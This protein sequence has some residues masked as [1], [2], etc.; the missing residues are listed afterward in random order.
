MSRIGRV[1]YVATAM[2]AACI[3]G[4]PAQAGTYTV[5]A[6]WEAT[7]DG[8]HPV[9]L[10]PSTEVRSDCAG[11]STG[12]PM[13]A[14]AWPIDAVWPSGA[15]TGWAFTAP[16]GTRI[17]KFTAV[18]WSSAGNSRVSIARPWFRGV[19]DPDSAAAA[20]IEGSEK[21]VTLGNLNAERVVFGLRCLDLYCWFPGW[22]GPYGPGIGRTDYIQ[23]VAA[24]S[25]TL[26][27]RD[28]ESPTVNLRQAPSHAWTS[29]NS[30]H[31]SVDATDNVGVARINALLNTTTKATS[32]GECSGG[33]NTLRM[34]C[35]RTAPTVETT[36]DLSS[37]DDG[38]HE[39]KI[40]AADASGNE[41]TRVIPVWLDRA[42]PRAPR[43]LTVVGGDG[44][45]AGDTMAVTWLN[46]PREN[47]GVVAAEYELCPNDN[48]VGDLD[49]C[50]RGER[51]GADIARIDDLAVPHSGAWR[52]RIAL[53]DEAGNIDWDQTADREGIEFDSDAPSASFL[54][55]DP[56]D[57]A[58]VWL[59]AADDMSGVAG[60]E[61]EARRQGATTWHSLPT[62][63]SNGRFTA[64]LNDAELPE[65]VYSLRALVRDR[66]GHE[67][68]AMTLG[69]G[70]SLEIRLPVRADSALA[71]GRP[72]RVR[73]KSAKGK[74]KR[75]RTVLVPKP[76]T[77]YGDPVE[78]EGT[79]SDRV[80]N[81]RAGTEVKVLERV[82]LPGRDWQEIASVRTGSG[83]A[84]K[85]RA[86]PGPARALRFQYVGTA[87]TRPH[88]QDVELRVRAGVTLIPSRRRVRNGAQITF[89]GRVL[90][91]P[92]PPA[93]KILALQAQTS[94]GWRTF[95]TPRARA[96][97]GRFSVP[98]RFL[99]TTVTSRYRFRVVVPEESSYPYASGS[100][101]I[102]SVLVRG[103][104]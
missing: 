6:C 66:A 33:M 81:P 32:T 8:W 68:T 91:G 29:S 57:P 96:T 94:R 64:L 60:V 102:T 53:R 13:R 48:D 80:G 59:T 88:S 99:S 92:I 39:V 18:G 38:R 22:S 97:D 98:Y 103:D 71:V 85:F 86:L 2:V 37:L 7:Y 104:Q 65:G 25:I 76:T 84:F 100:S 3:S 63:H 47:A 44:W 101:T 56:A 87:T 31:L 16:R 15:S 5:R 41:T 19:W 4:S 28:D 77:R 46:P 82:G 55:F 35:T 27:I 24:H 95:A 49:G 50:V 83:G 93:G 9:I 89:G 20:A 12:T 73:V 70:T 17:T 51:S 75:Y 14:T 61:I 42:A 52:L 1:I 21:P 36:L 34:P 62:A 30:L 79:L 43:R 58:R 69:D 10:G 45:H 40:L 67:R 72:E 74:R 11:V 90:G 54:P 78:I 23:Y 26:T